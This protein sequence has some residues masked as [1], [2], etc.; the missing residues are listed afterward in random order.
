MLNKIQQI[1]GFIFDC[2]GVMTNGSAQIDS[3]GNALRTFNI[4][5]GFAV[6][7]AVKQG[8]ILAIISGGNAEGIRIRFE[9]LGLKSEDIYLAQKN[10]VK[11]F[12]DLMQRYNLTP[13]EVAYMGDDL[14][15]LPLIKQVG[16][17]TC[18]KD[19]CNDVIRQSKWVSSK[20]GGEGCARELIELTMKIQEK[21]FNS[22]THNF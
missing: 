18:P 2:D 15:D 12:E 19:A 14:P 22:D 3:H 5:D 7:H 17:S 16:L 4:K 8:Y 1:R 13:K 11:A 20:N 6:Q 9:A 21:W 10:K